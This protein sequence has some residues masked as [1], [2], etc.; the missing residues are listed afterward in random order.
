VRFLLAIVNLSSG[1]S[2]FPTEALATVDSAL[3]D[4]GLRRQVRSVV[5]PA[6]SYSITYDGPT[7][8]KAR[9]EGSVAPTAEQYRLAF[10]VEIEESVSFP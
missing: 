1:H 4:I 7:T 10:T 5:V 8:E 6:R 9:I 3:A 2:S